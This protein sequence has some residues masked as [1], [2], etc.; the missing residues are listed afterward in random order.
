[1]NSPSLSFPLYRA[2]TSAGLPLAGGKLYT[3]QAG[4]GGTVNQ[5]TY[6]DAALA[7]PNT[8]PVVLDSTGTAA[9]RLDPT[10]SYEFVLKDSGGALQNTVDGYASSF[11]TQAVFN[12]FLPHVTFVGMVTDSYNDAYFHRTAAYS[13]GTPGHVSTCFTKQTD[14]TGTG[15]ANYE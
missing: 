10:L 14:V 13:G 4:S 7:Q 6:Q 1:M 15:A 12:S 8:N 3:Y 2:F 11:L 5:T 9:V